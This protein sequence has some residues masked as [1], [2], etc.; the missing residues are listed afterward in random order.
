MGTGGALGGQVY[1]FPESRHCAAA[2]GLISAHF[3]PVTHFC[4]LFC[5]FPLCPCPSWRPVVPSLMCPAYCPFSE[6]AW[7]L[8][9]FE[10]PRNLACFVLV[11]KASCYAPGKYLDPGQEQPT[12]TRPSPLQAW[13]LTLTES[14]FLP[15]VIT[16]VPVGWGVQPYGAVAWGW[17][18]HPIASPQAGTAEQAHQEN[19][20]NHQRH[21]EI[22][23]LSTHLHFHRP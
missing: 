13:P 17:G 20:R 7:G 2:P 1:P 12:R 10:G 22:G 14:D 23:D 8:Q 18:E 5:S 3:G 11:T 16:L 9:S 15:C 6:L 21:P 19:A 4:Y